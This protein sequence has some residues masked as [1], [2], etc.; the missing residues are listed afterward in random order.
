MH[1]QM[2]FMLAR[3]RFWVKFESKQHQQP[4]WRTGFEAMHYTT[5]I[6]AQALFQT[7]ASALDL[8]QANMA[9]SCFDNCTCFAY[10]LRA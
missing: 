10:V 4:S 8:A 9:N 5:I 2:R 6:L 1:V 7:M 3:S